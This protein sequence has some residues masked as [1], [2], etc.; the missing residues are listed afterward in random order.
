MGRIGIHMYPNKSKTGWV[1]AAHKK[2]N[3]VL[4]FYLRLFFLHMKTH[5]FRKYWGWGGLCPG[6]GY[7]MFP[8]KKIH[9]FFFIFFTN[10]SKKIRK[11]WYWKSLKFCMHVNVGYF[12]T[13]QRKNWSRALLRI[14]NASIYKKKTSVCT[15]PG[16]LLNGSIF[17]TICNESS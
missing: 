1:C 11:V 7:K 4:F 16:I 17:I 6:I 9:V 10:C 5:I 8:R 14:Q 13:L 15:L 12:K 3:F 2:W